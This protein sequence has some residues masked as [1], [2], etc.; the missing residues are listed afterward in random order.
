M[1]RNRYNFEN[2]IPAMRC[3]SDLFANWKY[4]PVVF[5]VET[6]NEVTPSTTLM[7]A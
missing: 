1:A 6:N 3:P 7:S 4:D 5:N 2:W